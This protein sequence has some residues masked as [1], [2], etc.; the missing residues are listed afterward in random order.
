MRAA[1]ERSIRMPARRG[2]A[3]HSAVRPLTYA[4]TKGIS[5][6]IFLRQECAA[7]K[8]CTSAR[9][10]HTA[11]ARSAAC[12]AAPTKLPQ[13]V[14]LF[15]ALTYLLYAMNA[16]RVR[17]ALGM[18]PAASHDTLDVVQPVTAFCIVMVSL[19]RVVW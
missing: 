12:R 16:T 4:H 8:A 17:D 1:A 7:C 3:Q 2:R 10:S 13:L 5:Y 9:S 6:L 14:M 11:D 18:P 19:V 15:V